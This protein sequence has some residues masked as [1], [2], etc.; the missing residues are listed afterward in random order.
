MQED[1]EHRTIAVS[2]SA[3]KLTARVL[4]KALMAVAKKICNKYQESQTPRGKQSLEKLMNHN[5]PTNSIPLDG[6]K[7][8]TQLF[9][10]LARKYNVDYAFHETEP[11]KYLLF[12]KSGQAD[13]ITACFTEY[14]KCVLNKDKK[15]SI[16]EQLKKFANYVRGYDPQDKERAREAGQHER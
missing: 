16:L 6:D 4:A 12:F 11:G 15:T 7:S 1:V 5:V 14:S 8:D 3:T 2:I 13:A 10:Q 9:D